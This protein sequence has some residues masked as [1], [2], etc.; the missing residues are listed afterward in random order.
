MK[1][2]IISQFCLVLILSLLFPAFGAYQPVQAA[3]AREPVFYLSIPEDDALQMFRDDG[4]SSAVSP[5]RSV[6]SIAIGTSGTIVYFDH[7]ETGFAV[8]IITGAEQV[9]GD[10]DL[11]NGCPPNLNNTPNPCLELTD[12][13][14]QVGDVIVLD[15]FVIVDGSPGS[16]YRDVAKVYYDG[17]DKLATTFPT[18]VSRAMWPTGSGSLQAGGVEMFPTALWGTQ[19]IS[20]MQED[21]SAP[22]VSTGLFEDVRWFILAGAG[23]A[24][25]DVDANGD[26]DFLDINDLDDFIL[27]EG[28][29]QVVN[30]IQRGASLNVVSGNPVQVNVL[31]ADTADT[32]E[33]RWSAL[34]P[35]NNWSNDYYSSVGTNPTGGT[36]CTLVWLYNPNTSPIIVNF[37]YGS[38]ASGTINVGANGN[39]YSPA[40]PLDSGAHFFTDNPSDVFLPF[41]VTDCTGGGQIMDWDTPLFATN[42][43]TPDLLIGWAPGCTDESHLGVCRDADGSPTWQTATVVV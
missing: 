8:D 27:N 15:N 14:L 21:A 40:I 24:T 32:Y 22:G 38:G 30:G 7:W 33:M 3:P 20:P 5:V 25:V 10:S 23:G 9:W 42:Q 4:G 28:D 36:G 13:S 17:R 39:A 16:Y 2:R 26:G 11:A 1:K 37:V 29:K 35:R 6:T 43:L 12:D 19:Y 34:I 41:S 31:Y 18:T